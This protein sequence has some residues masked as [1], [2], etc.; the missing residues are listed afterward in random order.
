VKAAFFDLDAALLLSLLEAAARRGF[1]RRPDRSPQWELQSRLRRQ[2]KALIAA[3]HWRGHVVVLLTDAGPQWADLASREL[4]ADGVLTCPDPPAAGPAL[5]LWR[6]TA[7]TRFCL[8]YHF[9]PVASYG[10]GARSSDWLWLQTLGH[11]AVAHPSRELRWRAR[12]SAWPIVNLNGRC[13]LKPPPGL[14]FGPS[15]TPPPVTLT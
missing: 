2:A 7:V 12:L 8:R 3:H 5:P 9:S 11:P 1:C 6:A 14:A 13:D 4:D 10:Y 15:Q